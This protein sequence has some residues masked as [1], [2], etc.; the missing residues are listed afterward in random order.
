MYVET[1]LR[2][3]WIPLKTRGGGHKTKLG[4]LQHHNTSL[5]CEVIFC[6]PP[7]LEQERKRKKK[8]KPLDA[9]VGGGGCHIS[10]HPN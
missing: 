7:N 8:I 1:K 10:V 9:G 5:K 4:W 2:G 3:T 6:R